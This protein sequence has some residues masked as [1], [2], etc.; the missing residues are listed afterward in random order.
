MTLTFIFHLHLYDNPKLHFSEQ[1][2]F[3]FAKSLNREKIKKL[4]HIK[5]NTTEKNFKIDFYFKMLSK[6]I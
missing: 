4:K 2:Y 1:G 6:V 3:T 5:F